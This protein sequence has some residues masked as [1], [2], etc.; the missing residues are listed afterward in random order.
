MAMEESCAVL[1]EESERPACMCACALPYPPSRA[2]STSADG[3]QAAAV[4][5]QQRSTGARGSVCWWRRHV[6][7]HISFLHTARPQKPMLTLDSVH[8]SCV[9]L[10]LSAPEV[11]GGPA[12]GS[13]ARCR[14]CAGR[15]VCP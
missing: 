2:A 1:Q 10:D 4:Y 12:A 3:W 14:P 8:L 9:H 6:C 13:R 5:H 11:A 15:A 7:N